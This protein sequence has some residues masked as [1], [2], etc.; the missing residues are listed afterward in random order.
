[1]GDLRMQYL[2]FLFSTTPAIWNFSFIECINWSCSSAFLP[3]CNSLQELSSPFKSFT[4][5]FLIVASERSTYIASTLFAASESFSW[6]LVATSLLL[7]QLIHIV[8]FSCYISHL[9]LHKKQK[10]SPHTLF[11]SKLLWPLSH[12]T[13]QW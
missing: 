12:S 10:A 1:M 3:I 5:I 9:D 6:S 13:V 4:F 11:L 7:N 2:F 8:Y